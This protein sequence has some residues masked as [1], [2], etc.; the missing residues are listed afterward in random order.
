MRAWRI[1]TANR[2]AQ[3]FG[4]GAAALF[5]STRF[6]PEVPRS[7]VSNWVNGN[8]AVSVAIF[9]VVMVLLIVPTLN[10]INWKCPRCGELFSYPTRGRPTCQ[11]CGL[12]KYADPQ[13]V[14]G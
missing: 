7:A 8:V 5:L 12:A 2:V 4:F 11:H 1:Y 6:L 13:D 10:L 3:V 9:V 14:T